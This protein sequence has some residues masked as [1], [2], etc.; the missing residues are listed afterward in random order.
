M[1]TLTIN[2]S[3]HLSGMVVREFQTQK[4]LSMAHTGTEIKEIEDIGDVITQPHDGT[5]KCFEITDATIIGVIQL[6]SYNS[7]MNCKA[8]VETINTP[9]GN[10]SKCSMLQSR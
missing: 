9:I 10:Y 3:Y 7:C 6:D 2:G 4:Y 8:R 5:T 1:D